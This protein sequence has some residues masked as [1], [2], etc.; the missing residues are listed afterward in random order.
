VIAATPKQGEPL[1]NFVLPGNVTSYT[2]SPIYARTS[3]YLTRWYF[4]IGSRVKKG[5]LLA[6]IA[7]LKWISNWPR[8]RLS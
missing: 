5:D 2:D 4:D 6:E 3:G 7:T 8:P 1:S